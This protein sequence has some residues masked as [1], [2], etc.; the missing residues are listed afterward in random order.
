LTG[1]VSL[2]RT[3]RTSQEMTAKV[4]QQSQENYGQDCGGWTRQPGQDNQDKI[5]R[6]GQQAK[7]NQ[8]RTA[9]TGPRE[10][11]IQ[12]RKYIRDGKKRRRLPEH[13]SKDRSARTGQ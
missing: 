6:T 11:Q 3:E 10:K 5:A 8:D 1:Q 13:E 7:E 9:G 2:D 12:S 4:G